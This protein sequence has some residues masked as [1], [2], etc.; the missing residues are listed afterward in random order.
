[1][2]DILH[3]RMRKLWLRSDSIFK[4][5]SLS[6]EQDRL[7][8]IIHG[9]TK[10]VIKSKKEAFKKGTR[11][12]LAVIIDKSF[13]E[14]FYHSFSLHFPDHHYQDRQHQFEGKHQC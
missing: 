1:M 3:L 6:G 14:L 5:S 2:C 13:K 10:R 4:F 11:G 7:L 8:G 12:S 9:L